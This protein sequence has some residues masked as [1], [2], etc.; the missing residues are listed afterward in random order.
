MPTEVLVALVGVVS[1]VLVKLL[2]RVWQKRD[3]KKGAMGQLSQKVESISD[4]LDK[5]IADDERYHII[6]CRQRIQRFNDDILHGQKHTK[7]FFDSILI[8]IGDYDRYSA[9]HPEFRNQ[10][11]SMAED[12]IKRIYKKC[13]TDKSFL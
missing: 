9:S 10:V 13:M 6:Q 5:H 7:E 4:R 11:T 8:D 3:E 12:N 2:D 1:A